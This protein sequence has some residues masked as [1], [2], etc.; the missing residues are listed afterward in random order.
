V[1]EVAEGIFVFR[2]FLLNKEDV[3][4]GVAGVFP[5]LLLLHPLPT[6]KH[7]RILLLPVLLMQRFDLLLFIIKFVLILYLYLNCCV[8]VVH[9]L[10]VLFVRVEIRIASVDP[11]S[12]QRHLRPV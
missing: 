3:C 2:C 10:G 1:Q 9:S 6:S 4:I 5:A 8:E 11:L 12:A 7:H